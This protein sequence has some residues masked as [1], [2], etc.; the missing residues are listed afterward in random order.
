MRKYL[1]KVL[2]SITLMLTLMGCKKEFPNVFNM[3]DVQLTFHQSQPYAVDGDGYKEIDAL[4][5]VLIDYTIE[6]PESDMYQIALFKMGGSSPVL[7]V[8]V[9]DPAQRRIYSG[10]FKLYAKDLGAGPTSYRIWAY[11]KDGVYLGDGGKRITIKVTSDMKYFPNRRLYVLDTAQVDESYIS[12]A[13][14]KTYSYTTGA[15]HS[16]SID[17]ASYLRVDTTRN[18]NGTN[19]YTYSNRFYSLSTEPLPFAL[20]DISSWTKRQTLFSAPVNSNAAFFNNELN[21]GPKIIAAAKAKPPVLKIIN[22]AIAANKLIYFL[23]PEGQY[24]VIFTQSLSVDFRNH[25]YTQISI[26]LVN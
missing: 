18:S 19:S 13:D 25:R 11:D 8:P 1:I 10:H 2:A 20:H 16:A 7:K 23:T 6:S 5:S 4:D 26:K 14:G 17:L 9:N 21:T 3:F 22:A 24:G 15:P 12:L